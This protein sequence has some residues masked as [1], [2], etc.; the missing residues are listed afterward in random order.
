MTKTRALALVPCATSLLL[1]APSSAVADEDKGQT[2]GTKVD[3]A[4]TGYKGEEN[5]LE[6]ELVSANGERVTRRMR[7]RVRE[8]GR[9][10]Q[11]TITIVW[12]AD[13][14]DT[15]LLTWSHRDKE[16]DQW[17]Y[18]PSIKRVKRISARGRTGSFVGSEF[19]YED[20]VNVWWV[21]KFKYKYLR[22]QKVGPRDTW[23][24]ER[25]P[26]DPESGYS[27]QQVWIDKEYLTALRIDF[28]DRKGSLF[29]TGNFKS[30]KKYGN[31]WRADRIDM[32]N[33]QTGKKSSVI[34]KVRSLGK[35]FTDSDFS[36]DTLGD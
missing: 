16:D 21:D 34:W 19:S 10:E 31:K 23:V 8:H 26:R 3:Q 17:L 25:V 24:V 11:A 29:K 27:K 18:L 12:P 36:A 33:R 9:D 15:R 30:F 28:Y 4:W 2:I 13:Q 5:E 22:D 35:T 1:L 14:K 32:D 6:L 20:L 7:G